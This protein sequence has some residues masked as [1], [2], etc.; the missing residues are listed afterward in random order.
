M[1]FDR[2]STALEVARAHDLSG[3]LTI[4]T[5]AGSGLGIE[6]ARA[7]ADAGAQLILGVRNAE[8]GRGVADAI[9]GETGQPVETLELNLA[10]PRSVRTFAADVNARHEA[11][12]LLVANAGV[13]K[14][15]EAHLENGLDVRFATN[16]LG[17][18]L[19][20][21]LLLDRL[22]AQGARIVMLS[23]AAHKGKRIDFS[24]LQWR[25]RERNDLAAY[26]ES[27]TANI[28]FA[29]EATR[30][31]SGRGIFANAVLPGSV[32]TGLQ[33][34]HGEEL[35]R[36]IGFILPDGKPNP[37][38]KTVEQGAATTLWACCAAEL[39]GRGGLV[40]ED[41]ALAIPTG[42]DTHPWNGY[43][44]TVMVPAD[45]EELWRV[46]ERLVA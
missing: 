8:A 46:S 29:M 2:H 43:D 33:R 32:L 15:P 44:P 20:A 11:V 34:Y 13:S 41:C 28:L 27:K 38:M 30:Q 24:D 1:P 5:G 36:Q 7:L 39:E 9:A 14:T 45:A 10:D 22:S 18:F 26:G 12:H 6:T 35:K 16:H 25:A 40:L 23:S 37:V 19:L 4:V 42:P 3:R 21:N 17:H 31:W